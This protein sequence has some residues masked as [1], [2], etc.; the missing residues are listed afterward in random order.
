MTSRSSKKGSTGLHKVFVACLLTLALCLSATDADA[1]RKKKKATPYNPKAASLVMDAYSGRIL[2][3]SNADLQCYP[4]SLT[5][6]MTLYLLFE[7][8]QQGK[9]TLNTRMKVSSRAAAQAPSRLGLNPGAT[10]RVEDAILALVTKSANDIAVVV[11]EHLGGTE[12][13][14][15]TLMT[16]KAKSL[17]MSRTRYMNASGL[18]NKQQLT[19]A[20]DQARL[21]HRMQTD[22]PRYYAYFGTKTFAWDGKVFKNHNHLLGKYEGTNGLKTGYTAASGFN[23]TTTVKRDGKSVIGVVLG[24]KTARARDLQ[25]ISILDRT[26]PTAIAMRD[27]NTKLASLDTTTRFSTGPAPKPVSRPDTAALDALVASVEDEPDPDE[28]SYTGTEQVASLRAHTPLRPVPTVLPPVKKIAVAEIPK[29]APAPAPIAIAAAPV[30]K[31]VVLAAVTAPVIA[32]PKPASSKVATA[33]LDQAT[34]YALAALGK[35]E[36]PVRSASRELGNM[37]ITPANA[38]EGPQPAAPVLG[39][40]MAVNESTLR[41]PQR[42]WTEKD[43]LIPSGTWII[44]IGAYSDQGDAVSRIRDAIKAAPT[45]L[46]TAVP[47]TIPVLSADN[48]TLYRSRFGGFEGEKQA[49][50]ACGRLA[51]QKISCIAIPPAN[52]IMP[53]DNG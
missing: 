6:V 32:A 17:G 28:A 1:A 19:T 2:Y 52:W 13:Q 7:K 20:R 46:A 42:G 8:L 11:A 41:T 30:A 4:A 44:Q 27:G 10:I 45:E 31:P 40:R 29:S 43:P 48:R 12:Q 39:L 18:P 15:A 53:T 38:S 22:F 47:V 37:I 49:R 51:R 25:M 23:L 14:F 26:M 21:A 34:A 33:P 9:V 3:S 50:N 24:G 36:G 35:A 16:A 5:K